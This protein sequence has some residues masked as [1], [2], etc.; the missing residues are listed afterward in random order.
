[1]FDMPNLLMTGSLSLEDSK[2]TDPF[3]GIERRFLFSFRGRT[4]LGFRH[5]IP[6]LKLNYGLNWMNM[7]DGGRVRY[8]IDDIE[9]SGGDPIWTTFV[10]W[11]GFNDM[12]F[13]VDLMRFFNDGE[14]CRERQRFVG[15]ISS[16]ILEEIEDQCSS[17]GRTVSLRINGT[18]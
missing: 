14:F 3:L 16:G 18:F 8:D 13:R 5:D 2:I 17:S 7:F 1:M 11:V 4:S 6:S 15:R 12:T 10:E 9:L